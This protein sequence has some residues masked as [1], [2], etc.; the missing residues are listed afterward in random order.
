VNSL[1][2]QR[3][4]ASEQAANKIYSDALSEDPSAFEYDS[5]YDSFKA[6]DTK[7]HALSQSNTKEEAPVSEH[8]TLVSDIVDC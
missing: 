2:T 7:S 5:V 3:S 6:A 1:L 8:H 4:A